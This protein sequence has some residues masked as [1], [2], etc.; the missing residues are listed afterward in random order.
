MK[1]LPFLSLFL[2]FILSFAQICAQA[3]DYQTQINNAE[4]NFK[5]GNFAAA[6]EIY[7]SLISVEKV[8]NPFVYYN[9]ANAYYR[10]GNLGEAVLNIEKAYRLLPRDADIKNN[11]KYLRSLAGAKEDFLKDFF[12]GTFSLNELSA[13]CFILIALLLSAGAF[14]KNV[15]RNRIIT[16][17]AVL[18]APLLLW[19]SY[20][21]KVE[22]LSGEAV[23][24]QTLTVRS[25][26]GENNP[27]IFEINEG[28]TVN[29][30]SENAGWSAISVVSDGETLKGWAESKNLAA[31]NG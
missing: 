28:K 16:V 6:A 13:A 8:N 14:K 10:N 9:L 19:T 1:K 30:I 21:I 15:L 7:E 25:G 29:I 17:C 27:E 23:A 4:E 18:L 20:K 12:T 26:P 22:L 11:R 3:N 24:V 5:N 2:F 31:I